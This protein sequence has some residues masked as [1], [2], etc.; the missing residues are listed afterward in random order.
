MT[1]YR[2]VAVDD[3]AYADWPV[4]IDLDLF[5]GP[6]DHES[7][8][9][10]AVRLVA[11]ADILTELHHAGLDDEITALD[12]R[13]AEALTRTVPLRSRPRARTRRGAVA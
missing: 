3:L 9:E 12:A 1:P 6:L 13:Y 7:D 10:Q 11:A 5:R 4:G 2:D 8:E